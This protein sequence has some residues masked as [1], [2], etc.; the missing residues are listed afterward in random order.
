MV[1]RWISDEVKLLHESTNTRGDTRTHARTHAHPLHQTPTLEL[2]HNDQRKERKEKPK[3]TEVLGD[4]LEGAD[5]GGLDADHAGT[6]G[7]DA[8]M[9]LFWCGLIVWIFC[10]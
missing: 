9:L 10:V 1:G 5:A 3:R 4:E 2:T 7:V 6:L 8:E